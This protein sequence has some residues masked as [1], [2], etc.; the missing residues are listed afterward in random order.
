MRKHL[1]LITLLHAS[2]FSACSF[3]PGPSEERVTGQEEFLS[4]APA[5]QSPTN[6]GYR[7][8]V[9][10]AGATAGDS[11]AAA[12]APES[13]GGGSAPRS[14]EETDIYRIDG[15]RLYY[16]NGY[17]GL[18]VF[19]ITQIDDPKLLGRSP[20]YGSPVEMVVR[21][22]VANVIVADWYGR[23]ADGAPFRGS[24]VRQI[25]ATDPTQMQITGEALLGGYVRDARVVGDVLYTVSE[26]YGWHYGWYGGYYGDAAVGVASGPQYKV[27]ITSVRFAGGPLEQKSQQVY[28]GYSGIFNVTDSAIMLARALPMTG[29]PKTELIYVDIS[30]PAGTMHQRGK[31]TVNGAAQGWGAD[32]GRFNLDFSDGRYARLIGCAQD[33]CYNGGSYVLQIAD[34]LDPDAP[35]LT[36]SLMIDATGWNVAA[37]FDGP[38][39]YMAPSDGYYGGATGGTPIKVFDLS[40]PTA[41]KFAGETIVNGNVWMFMPAGTSVFALGSD[42]DSVDYGSK[43]TL[44]YIDVSNVTMPVVRGTSAFGEG[45]AWTPAAGTF[46]AFTL[47]QAQG[48]VVLPFSGWSYQANSYN[49]GLQIISFDANSVTTRGAAKTKGWVTRGVFAKGRLLSMSDLSLAV[50]DYTDLA[51]PA[52]TREL[53]LARNVIDTAPLGDRVAH[54]STDWW[55]YDVNTSTLRT[56]SAENADESKS[57]EALAELDIPG[58]NARM[59]RNDTLVYVVTDVRNTVACPQASGGAEKGAPDIGGIGAE[60]TCYSW[61]QRVSAVDLSG[62][63]PVVRGFVE[64][65]AVQGWY[66]SY[67]GFYGCF[68]YDWYGGSSIVQVQGDALAFR[69]WTIDYSANGY[70]DA[71][72]ALFV[73]DLKNPD[74]P[75]VAATA[76]TRDTSAWWGQLIAVGDSLYATDWQWVAGKTV[77]GREQW[78]VRYWLNEVDLSDRAAPKIKA[79]INVPGIVVGGSADDPSILYAVDYR[80]S[81]NNVES[82]IAVLKVQGG[83]AR[84]LGAKNLEGYTGSFFVRGTKAY[85]SQQEYQRQ[86]G[87][88]PMVRL[89]ELDLSTPENITLRTSAPQAGWGWLLAVEGDRAILTSGWG[90]GAVDVYRLA[91]GADPVFDETVRTRGY[92]QNAIHRDGNILYLSSG[93]WGVQVIHL[94]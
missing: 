11:A 14:I 50:V 74:A 5:G 3:S 45:W 6:S 66:G 60:A 46:K 30:D 65:P 59:Y 80:W 77:S 87:S 17:R 83:R 76:I 24:I 22:G 32:N 94:D 90:G 7:S 4:A 26:D 43:V 57:L 84:L 64:L 37:R 28:E 51:S 86:D 47:D 58:T 38:R 49:N 9:N 16:L 62:T 85:A 18:M 79:R 23:L 33:Y 1:G 68:Y 61:T 35:T 27:L 88:Q 78:Y 40:D 75:S 55:D 2:L 19:D 48:L 12:P 8:E 42:Y 54:L 29:N 10:L 56:L 73:V 67:W 20:I 82:E 93:Y 25:D 81:T 15:D 52:V 69:R 39:F 71:K 41:P 72:H 44:H 70:D 63:T 92:W 31:L 53:T 34:F 36:Y 91:E 21:N 89:L 13:A